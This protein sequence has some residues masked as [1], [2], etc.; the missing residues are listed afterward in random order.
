MAM[1]PFMYI[2]FDVI[3]QA[4]REMDIPQ[5]KVGRILVLSVTMGDYAGMC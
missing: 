4:S 2:G 3:P 5:K 1:T